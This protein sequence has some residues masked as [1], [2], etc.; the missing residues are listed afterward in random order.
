[1]YKKRKLALSKHKKRVARLKA[2]LH[3]RKVKG[4]ST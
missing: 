1:M 3:N 4:A 2:K